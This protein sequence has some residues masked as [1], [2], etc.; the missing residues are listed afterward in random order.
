M[1]LL[2]RLNP[3]FYLIYLFHHF[4]FLLS[5]LIELALPNTDPLLRLTGFF[6]YFLTFLCTLLADSKVLFFPFYLF[7][8]TAFNCFVPCLFGLQVLTNPFEV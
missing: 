1:G 6:F 8:Q 5:Y 7:I 4:I 2:L 3:R